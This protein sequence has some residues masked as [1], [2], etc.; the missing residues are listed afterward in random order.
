[1]GMTRA[2]ICRKA[3]L[4]RA[5]AFT[6]EYQRAARA[7][8]PRE[9]AVR[10]GRKGFRSA[11]KAGLG[12]KAIE[13]TAA[14]HLAHP[15]KYEV[16]CME[17]LDDMSVSFQREVIIHCR[18]EKEWLVDF[19]VGRKVIEVNG[20]IHFVEALDIAEMASTQALKLEHL[21]GEGLET[22][23]IDYMEVDRWRE[24]LA[25]FLIL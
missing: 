6:P 21:R 8:L 5:K 25:N 16:M 4:A 15:S 13:G 22:L 7:A 3:G 10:A 12:H 1:M 24:L 17:M 19:L 18:N 23:V 11:M 20:E 14:Y 9:V 2:E